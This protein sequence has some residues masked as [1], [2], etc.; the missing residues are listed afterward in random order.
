VSDLRTKYPQIPEL[1]FNALV[2]HREH[3]QTWTHGH[4]VTALL[5]ND[6]M[7]AFNRADADCLEAMPEIVRFVYNDLPAPSHGSAEKVAAW[8]S[9]ARVPADTSNA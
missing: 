4:F 9:S 8:L 1:V 3:T 7:E 6:L 5:S 2:R